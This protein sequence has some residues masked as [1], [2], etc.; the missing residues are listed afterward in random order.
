MLGQVEVPASAFGRSVLGS[1]EALRRACTENCE[2][3][4]KRTQLEEHLAGAG[5]E[6][7][8]TKK[9]RKTKK[10]RVKSGRERTRF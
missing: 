7:S 5:S 4:R 8:K 9:L 2:S 6:V 10:R 3:P 1:E